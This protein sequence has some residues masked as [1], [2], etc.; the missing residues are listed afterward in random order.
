MSIRITLTVG[1]SIIVC[2]ISSLI[3]LDSVALLH[4][5]KF[6]VKLETAVGTV[7][8]GVFSGPTLSLPKLDLV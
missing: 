4:T 2:Q 5:Y 6:P 7:T 8:L 1:G 3:G